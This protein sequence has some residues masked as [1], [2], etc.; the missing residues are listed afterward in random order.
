LGN[1]RAVLS[2]ARPLSLSAALATVLAVGTALVAVLAAGTV[3]QAILQASAGG[4]LLMQRRHGLEGG[5]AE[6]NRAKS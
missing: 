6:V 2:S 5:R 3:P 4:I 1:G